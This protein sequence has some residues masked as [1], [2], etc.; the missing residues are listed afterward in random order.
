MVRIQ[1]YSKLIKTTVIIGDTLLCGVIFELFCFFLAG[2]HWEKILSAP[3][4]QIILTLLLC[5]VLCSMK[6]SVILYKRKV[7]AYQIV[8]LV[9]LNVFYFAVL[10]GAILAIGQYMDVWSYF[11]LGYILTK[12]VPSIHNTIADCFPYCPPIPLNADSSLSHG[13]S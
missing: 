13:N 7:Y 6:R 12:T 8:T 9:F 10:S 3:K 4:A 11:F 2:T 5:Y 1:S